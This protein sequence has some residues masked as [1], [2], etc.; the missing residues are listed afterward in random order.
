[1]SVPADIGPDFA[2]SRCKKTLTPSHHRMLLATPAVSVELSSWLS[3][4][5]AFLARSALLAVEPL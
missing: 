4:A 5:A 2:A 3:Y 1:M